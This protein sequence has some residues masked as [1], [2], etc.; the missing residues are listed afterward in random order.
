MQG[1]DGLVGVLRQLLQ[2]LGQQHPGLEVAGAQAHGLAGEALGLL[3]VLGGLVQG[4]GREDQL[5][6]PGIQWQGLA[7]ALGGTGE[8]GGLQQGRGLQQGPLELGHGLGAG[9]GQDAGPVAGEQ[10]PGADQVQVLLDEALPALGEG[11][12][13]QLALLLHFLHQGH[14]AVAQ[15][16]FAAFQLAQLVGDGLQVGLHAA[17]GL[18]QARDA[19]Q[20]VLLQVFA[21]LR[22]VRLVLPGLVPGENEQ[23]SAALHAGLPVPGVPGQA[24]L[25]IGTGQVVGHDPRIAG[26]GCLKVLS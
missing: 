9:D 7:Q 5:V 8:V 14:E 12:G 26:P 11:M 16:D 4:G 21:T 3:E 24:V 22:L 19:L 15:H 17:E 25:A 10:L 13:V 6:V 18:L 1:L 2:Q 23:A 20:E